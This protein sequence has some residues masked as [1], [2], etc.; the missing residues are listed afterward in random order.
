MAEDVAIFADEGEG[1]LQF[2]ALQEDDSRESSTATAGGLVMRYIRMRAPA[3]LMK[4]RT[5]SRED[6]SWWMSSRSKG[7]MKVWLSLVRTA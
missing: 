7:V 2:L 5:S 6:V 1:A 4:S 3:A